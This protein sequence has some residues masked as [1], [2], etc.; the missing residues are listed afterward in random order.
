MAFTV[1]TPTLEP[2]PMYPAN[3][4]VIRLAGDADEAALERLAQLDSARPLQHPILVAEIRGRVAAALDM[5]E[6]RAIA[7]PFQP[8]AI[9]RAQ[10]QARAAAFEAAARTPDVAERIRAA[11]A[12]NRTVYA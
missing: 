4:H 10:L 8:T 3:N 11:L 5:D 6:R 2:S 1:M 12:R 7:D 9:L